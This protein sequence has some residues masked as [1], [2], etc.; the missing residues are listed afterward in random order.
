[1]YNACMN[2][3]VEYVFC[4]NF[5]VDFAILLAVSLTFKVKP[6]YFRLALGATVGATCAVFS[7]FAVGVW[8]YVVKTACLVAM[9]VTAWGI[10]K[11][12]WH[13]LLT[14]AYTFVLGGAIIGVFGL[15]QINYLDGW[16]LYQTAVPLFVYV[17][18]V[19]FVSVGI[20]AVVRYVRVR[21]Q[22][23]PFVVQAQ[24][25]LDKEYTV[26]GLC[27][28]GNSATH[29]GVAVCFVT[30]SFEGFADY[31]ARQTVSGKT[32]SVR[33]GT[34]AGNQVVR[35]VS[36][37]ITANGVTSDVYLALPTNKCHTLYNVVLSSIFCEG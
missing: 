27:D 25:T 19:A 22:I 18:A 23:A 28:S 14:V 20:F 30:K 11:L 12:I 15:L 3:Y 24:V 8:L 4:D 1:M 2:V 10:K 6:N 37:Q 21:R 13:I 5:T 34:V 17:W 36:A 33:V 7:V 9:C 26:Q 35:A 16:N 32:V 29:N 31:F